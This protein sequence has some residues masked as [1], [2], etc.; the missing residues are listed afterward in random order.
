MEEKQIWRK[1]SVCK[2]NIAYKSIY[3]VCSV[4]SCSKQRA[5]TQFCSVTCWDVHNGVLLHRSAGADER[6][7]PFGPT[8]EG[9]N[10]HS[11]SSPVPTRRIVS[12]AKTSPSENAQSSQTSQDILVVV[13]KFKSYIKD[14]S[15][16]SV[17]G[18]VAFLLSNLLRREADRAIENAKKSG[19]KTVVARD[20]S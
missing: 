3:Y 11:S 18:D 15:D 12:S 14:K 1:C 10:S 5:P 4:S 17:S 16:M 9:T 8:T 7:A 19:R 6:R 20:F 2:K 13:S